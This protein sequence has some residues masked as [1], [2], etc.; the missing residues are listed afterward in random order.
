MNREQIKYTAKRVHEIANDKIHDLQDLRVRE[1]FEL[2]FKEKYKQIKEG[3]AKLLPFEELAT[4]TDLKDAYVF[5][6]EKE[7]LEKVKK[8]NEDLKKRITQIEN[9][10]DKLLDEVHLGKDAAQV[11]KLLNEFAAK[12]F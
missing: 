5:V 4:Y 6:G 2:P 9:Q 1:T 3:K 10:R 8:A 12:K 11:I 7:H